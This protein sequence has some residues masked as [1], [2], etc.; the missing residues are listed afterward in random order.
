MNMNKIPKSIKDIF[1]EIKNSDSVT[2]YLKGI[3]PADSGLEFLKEA[4]DDLKDFYIINPKK[5]VLK[6]SNF[7]FLVTID[8][9][10]TATGFNYLCTNAKYDVQV[11]EYFLKSYGINKFNFTNIV[12]GRTPDGELYLLEVDKDRFV[13]DPSEFTMIGYGLKYRL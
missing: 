9:I 11:A 12:S 7:N 8:L 10:E 4:I 5:I 1:Q 3:T 6:L 2:Y 13:H